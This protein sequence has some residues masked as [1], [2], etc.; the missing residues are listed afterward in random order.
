MS[1]AGEL[2]DSIFKSHQKRM[3]RLTELYHNK[4]QISFYIG[5]L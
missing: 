3:Q 5:K 4:K 1:C 2:P